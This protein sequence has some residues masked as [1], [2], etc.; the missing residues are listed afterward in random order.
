MIRPLFRIKEIDWT[1]EFNQRWM[2]RVYFGTFVVKEVETG[3]QWSFWNNIHNKFTTTGTGTNL[4][5]CQAQA[6]TLYEEIMEQIV[7]R[8]E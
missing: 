1:N 7:E 5:E 4:E 3:W 8:A 6:R 2:G